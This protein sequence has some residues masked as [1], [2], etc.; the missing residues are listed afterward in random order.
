MITQ[1]VSTNISTVVTLAEA[2]EHSRITEPDD[3]PQLQ[4]YLDSAHDMVEMWLN[5]KLSPTQMA[6]FHHNF[7][8]EIML[9]YP[10][11]TSIDSIV[12]EAFDGTELTVPVDGYKLVT[13][14]STL[15]FLNDYS[16]CKN[17]IITF[18]CGYATPEAVPAAIKHSIRMTCA[19]L[20][21]MREDAIVGTQVNEVPLTARNILR[22]YRV[23]T[24]Q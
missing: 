9:P 13:I 7:V 8:P 1:K 22:S 20:Y 2:K 6:G 10:P 17:F 12:C 21:E 23:R 24:T 16:T 4:L 19:T 15:R 5:R 11:V 3:D 14:T 18:T